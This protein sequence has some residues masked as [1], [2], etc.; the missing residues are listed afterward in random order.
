V[1]QTFLPRLPFMNVQFSGRLPIWDDYFQGFVGRFGYAQYA[2]PVWVSKLALAIAAGVLGLCVAGLV[3]ARTLL[4]GRLL[5]AATYVAFVASLFLLVG[6]A[7][8]NFRKNVGLPF[9][10]TRYL[11]PLLPLYAALVAVAL[12]GAGRRYGAAVAGALVALFVAHNFFSIVLT[13]ERYYT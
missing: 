10:Q 7:G 6:V 5:E 11:F 1:W 4:R 2:F 8:Y 9:E 12:R 3:R 13:L